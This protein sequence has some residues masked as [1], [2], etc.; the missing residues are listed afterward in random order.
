MIYMS[1]HVTLGS[2]QGQV[3][4]S[5][6]LWGEGMVQSADAR[7]FLIEKELLQLQFYLRTGNGT[8][9][10]KLRR[11]DRVRTLYC[12]YRGGLQTPS[13]RAE[14]DSKSSGMTDVLSLPFSLFLSSSSCCSSRC[15]SCSSC[16]CC[17]SFLFCSSSCCRFAAN[18]SCC[19][20]HTY[21][22]TNTHTYTLVTIKPTGELN[23]WQVGWQ[24]GLVRDKPD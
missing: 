19:C 3:E 7:L 15:F 17:S 14:R 5:P 2:V 22:H 21:I 18:S 20:L 23:Q 12:L 1:L 11:E 10:I 24:R 13:K 6:T 9:Q 4:P 16:L 8:F